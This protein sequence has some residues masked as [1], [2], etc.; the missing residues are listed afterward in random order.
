MKYLIALF[1]LQV[2]ITFYG[3][4]K[5][6][7]IGKFWA[8]KAVCTYVEP[9]I[10]DGIVYDVVILDTST[11]YQ[12]TVRIDWCETTIKKEIKKEMKGARKWKKEIR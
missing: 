5:H 1:I 11:V 3:I 12:D 9:V 7:A 2:V 8:N 10:I 6:R 4:D